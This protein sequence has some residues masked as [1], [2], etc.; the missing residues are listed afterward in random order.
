MLASFPPLTS[1]FVNSISPD[2]PWYVFTYYF[3]HLLSTFCYNLSM[4]FIYSLL[5]GT[6]RSMM[7][8]AP[9]GIQLRRYCMFHFLFFIIS[10][11]FF[12]LFP[13]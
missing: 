5:G 11:S 10:S 3:L 12:F 8:F 7:V 9:A 2:D 1:T 13:I 4:I 6:E